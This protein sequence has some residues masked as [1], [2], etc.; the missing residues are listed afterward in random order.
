MEQDGERRFFIEDVGSSSGTFVNNKRLS[1]QGQG[2]TPKEIKADDVI[3]LGED[4]KQKNENG[5]TL[6]FPF[7]VLR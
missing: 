5:G 7:V 4:Y 2:S 3:R 6:C 1:P